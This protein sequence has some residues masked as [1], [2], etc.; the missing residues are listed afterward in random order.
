MIEGF[1]DIELRV[2]KVIKDVLQVNEADVKKGSTIVDL[3]GDSLSALGILSK[4]EEEF[5]IGIP[6]EDALKINSFA[7]AVEVVRSRVG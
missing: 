7:T 3:G 4:L 5:D 2:R 6:D 1:D